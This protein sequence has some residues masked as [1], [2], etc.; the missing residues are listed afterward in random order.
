[1]NKKRLT[2]LIPY[3]DVLS[4][5]RFKTPSCVTPRQ[6]TIYTVYCTFN[7]IQVKIKEKN[8]VCNKEMQS[9]AVEAWWSRSS[10]FSFSRL[11]RLGYCGSNPVKGMVY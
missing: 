2:S 8:L 11:L 10:T 9:P 4:Q 3:W 1:M 5:D 6:P 7:W